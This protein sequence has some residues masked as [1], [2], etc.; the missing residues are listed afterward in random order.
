MSR[1]DHKIETSLEGIVDLLSKGVPKEWNLM[2]ILRVVKVT[3]RQDLWKQKDKESGPV[4][5]AVT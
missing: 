2:L 1:Y 3:A 4:L 5:K